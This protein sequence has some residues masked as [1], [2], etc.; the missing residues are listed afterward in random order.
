MLTYM[1]T[2]LWHA[3]ANL[4]V[5]LG[6]IKEIELH[7]GMG[8][9]VGQYHNILAHAHMHASISTSMHTI[10]L[11]SLAYISAPLLLIRDIE[12]SI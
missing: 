3:L 6:Q 10:F 4:L 1:Y 11:F 2:I 12:V 9:H 8:E 7:R 5:Q